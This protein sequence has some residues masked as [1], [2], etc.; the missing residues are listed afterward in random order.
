MRSRILTGAAAALV[1]GLALAVAG[2]SSTPAASGTGS[3]AVASAGTP[4]ATPPAAAAPAGDDAA[5]FCAAAQ[6]L[7]GAAAPK[8][9]EPGATA[10]ERVAGA[11]TQLAAVAPADVQPAVAAIAQAYQQQADGALP[12]SAA[13]AQ[14]KAPIKSLQDWAKAHPGCLAALGG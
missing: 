13:A 8:P 14:M 1:T 5:A 7:H 4:A 6:N 9:G 12:A 2:C 10:L 3:P 11:W